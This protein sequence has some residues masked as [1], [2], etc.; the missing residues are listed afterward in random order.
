MFRTWMASDL[1]VDPFEDNRADDRTGLLASALSPCPSLKTSMFR[2]SWQDD[3]PTLG[4]DPRV[5]EA[6]LRATLTGYY[7][8]CS[9]SRSES[10]RQREAACF[11]DPAVEV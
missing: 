4:Q 1:Y 2:L 6:N 5:I 9:E 3:E 7:G 11:D 10:A 8:H